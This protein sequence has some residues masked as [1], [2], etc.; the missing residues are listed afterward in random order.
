MIYIPRN[1]IKFYRET[2]GVINSSNPIKNLYSVRVLFVVNKWE[3][4]NDHSVDSLQYCW[5]EVSIGV[6]RNSPL[7]LPDAIFEF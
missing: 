7:L 6:Y 1:T 4:W 2:N 5:I 3:M